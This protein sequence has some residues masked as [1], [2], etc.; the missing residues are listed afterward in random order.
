MKKEIPELSKLELNQK[1][2]MELLFKCKPT[3]NTKNIAKANFYTAQSSKQAPVLPLDKDVIF[4]HSHLISY[5]LGQI[6][7]IHQKRPSMTPGAGI[8]NYQSQPWTSDNRALFALYYLGTSAHVMPLFYD[9]EN[10]SI[11]EK[12]NLFYNNLT[13]QPTFSPN[14]PNFKIKD[15]KLALEN[16]G[17]SIDGQSH[18]D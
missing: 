6:Q 7:A 3:A 14:D 2:V 1:N 15:A 11:T 9:G 18:V 8:I 16:L 5:W 13:L 4:A 17:I 12:L 10:G